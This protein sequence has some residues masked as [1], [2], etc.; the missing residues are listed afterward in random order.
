MGP[1]LGSVVA[2]GFYLFV[3]ALEYDTLNPAKHANG[4]DSGG[5]DPPRRCEQPEPAYDF[6][7]YKIIGHAHPDPNWPWN[8]GRASSSSR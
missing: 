8:G 5:L 4:K 2:A 1:F 3:K 6:D 7:E